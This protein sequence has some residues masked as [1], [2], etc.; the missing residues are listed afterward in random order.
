MI[1]IKCTVEFQDDEMSYLL[2]ITNNSP[3]K[4]GNVCVFL[5]YM[6]DRENAVYNFDCFD[7]YIDS[8]NSVTLVLDSTMDIYEELKNSSILKLHITG[9]IGDESR[10]YEKI[11]DLF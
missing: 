6:S 2:K 11:I 1:E 10:P 4:F 7:F 5:K 3:E 8:M 9:E